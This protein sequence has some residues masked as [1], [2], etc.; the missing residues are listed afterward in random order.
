MRLGG[1][2]WAEFFPTGM[3]RWRCWPCGGNP[4]PAVAPCHEY[5]FH[6]AAT[7]WDSK[8][9]G[10]MKRVTTL[11]RWEYLQMRSTSPRVI[12]FTPPNRRS[13]NRGRVEGTG[14]PSAPDGT[15]LEYSVCSPIVQPLSVCT[16]LALL[17]LIDRSSLPLLSSSM[18]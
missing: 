3:K 11:W 9:S 15:V 18:I 1:E 13:T 12:S 16:R 7:I 2:G 14:V 10:V 8:T 4:A 5:L 17:Y 6:G